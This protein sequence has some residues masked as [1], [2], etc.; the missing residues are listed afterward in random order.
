MPI[1]STPTQKRR[2]FDFNNSIDDLF[3][4]NGKIFPNSKND[5]NDFLK[6]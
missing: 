6:S 1:V 3:I 5:Q 4:I 2:N